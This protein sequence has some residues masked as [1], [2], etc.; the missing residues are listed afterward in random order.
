MLKEYADAA[1][2]KSDLDA[3]RT[4]KQA[5]VPTL[6]TRCTRSVEKMSH[7]GRRLRPGGLRTGARLPA[8][9]TRDFAFAEAFG[10]P[11]VRVMD[12]DDLPYTGQGMC[13]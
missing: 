3:R 4:R 10:L 9:D 5:G 1:A 7:L 2:R 13:Q 6:H 12:G 11:I 8:H